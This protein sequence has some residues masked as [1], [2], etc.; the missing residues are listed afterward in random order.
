MTQKEIRELVVEKMTDI[1]TRIDKGET[2]S[3][4]EQ[5]EYFDLLKKVKS[6]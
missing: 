2:I 5:K 3:E 4:A 1:R 6:N